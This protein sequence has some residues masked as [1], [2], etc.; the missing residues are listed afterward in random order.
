MPLRH[1][2]Y[3]KRSVAAVTAEKLLNHLESLDF[4]TLGEDYNISEEIVRIARPLRIKNIRP[5]QFLLYHISYGKSDTRPIEI[6]RWETEDR[7]RAAVDETVANLTIEGGARVKKISEFLRKS[8]DSV[9]VSF[10][11]DPPAAMFAWEVVRYFASE[12][13]GIIKADDGAWLKIGADYQP[14][15]V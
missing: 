8:V 14:G 6:D 10:G 11:I 9:S 2:V 5:G 3:S 7:H 4:L 1:T 12:F 15:P 13:D